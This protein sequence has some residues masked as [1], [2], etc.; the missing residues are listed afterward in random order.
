MDE[1]PAVNRLL[2]LQADETTY[3]QVL[4]VVQSETSDW[5]TMRQTLRQSELMGWGLDAQGK[6]KNFTKKHDPELKAAWDKVKDNREALKKRFTDLLEKYF[7]LDQAGLSL[8]IQGA[9]SVI[10]RLV[11]LTKDFSDDF[12]KITSQ[13][14]GFND[15]EHFACK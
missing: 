7:I 12:P 3:Q 4:Q 2:N 11:Q 8:A 5:D 15:L 9:G 1:A 14:V 6:R 10:S 13:S